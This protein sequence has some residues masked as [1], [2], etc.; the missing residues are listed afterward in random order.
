MAERKRPRSKKD[1][2][3]PEISLDLG[4]GGIFKG[5]GDFL[6]VVSKMAEEG[7]GEEVT[8]TGEFAVKGGRVGRQPRGVYGF[9]VRTV[10]GIPRVEKFGNVRVRTPEEGPMVADVREPLVDVFDEDEEIVIVAEIPGVGG[11]DVKVEVRDDILHL[12]TTGDR[13]YEKEVLLSGTVD[14]KSMQKKFTN[15]ILELRL[16]RK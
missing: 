2:E 1:E 3:G 9:S 16:K 8:R 11:E 10:K 14:P 6:D 7:E 4:L 13:K 12:E 15:G 5:L